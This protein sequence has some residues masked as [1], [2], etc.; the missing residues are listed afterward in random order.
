[1]FRSRD[2]GKYVDM[3]IQIGVEATLRID[4]VAQEALFALEEPF[5]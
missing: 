1:M 4:A 3:E 5:F 2:L